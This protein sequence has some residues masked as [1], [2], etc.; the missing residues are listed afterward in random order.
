VST[1]RGVFLGWSFVWLCCDNLRNANASCLAGLRTRFLRLLSSICGQDT[2]WRKGTRSSD[3]PF[4][5]SESPDSE[6]CKVPHPCD[7]SKIWEGVGHVLAP[8]GTKE[9]NP[10]GDA[11]RAN[12]FKWEKSLCLA[13]SDGDGKT[14]GAELGDPGTH[15]RQHGRTYPLNPCIQRAEHVWVQIAASRRV[16]VTQRRRRVTLA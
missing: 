12:G 11:F 9:L 10:F 2:E 8:G 3:R 6:L 15:S 16:G 4:H 1:K 14:N 5:A 7:P 13:D